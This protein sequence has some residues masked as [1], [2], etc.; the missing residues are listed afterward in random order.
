MKHVKTRLNSLIATAAFICAPC[1]ADFYFG[2][3]AGLSTWDDEPKSEGT[4]FEIYG[5]YQFSEF[6]GV[7]LAFTDPG[8]F[9][10]HPS[11]YET[12]DTDISGANYSLVLSLPLDDTFGLY[13]K[14]SLLDYELKS[15]YNNETLDKIQDQDFNYTLGFEFNAVDNLFV[16]FDYRY[17]PLNFDVEGSEID[18]NADTF[19]VGARFVF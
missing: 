10:Y 14:I 7:E 9:D 3:S 4:A 5:G 18:L 13:A 12:I 16:T 1:F 6:I 17:C 2:G 8:S 19:S 15:S 11:R